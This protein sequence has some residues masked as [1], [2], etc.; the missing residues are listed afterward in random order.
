MKY[1]YLTDDNIEYEYELNE[2][3]KE[4]WELVSVTGVFQKT[5]YFRRPLTS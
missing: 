5:Y 1:E 2:R 3:G 4:G